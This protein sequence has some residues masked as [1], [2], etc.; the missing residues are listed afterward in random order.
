MDDALKPGTVIDGR[1]TLV[2]PLG[3]GNSGAVWLAEDN[4]S[5]SQ[6]VALKLLHPRFRESDH[7][8]ERLQR[9]A[10]LLARL[11]HPNIARPIAVRVDFEHP[12]LA[13]ELVQGLPLDQWMAARAN[14]PLG[15]E[16]IARIFAELAAAVAYAHSEGVIHRDLKPQNVMILERAGQRY[17]KVLDFGIAKLLEPS[18]D[19]TTHGRTVGSLFY[20]SPEQTRGEPA[21]RASDTFALGVILFELLTLRRA[22]AWDRQGQHLPAF[23]VAAGADGQNTV[24]TVYDRINSAPRPRPSSLRPGLPAAWDRLVM[25][26][27]AIAPGDRPESVEALLEGMR[28]A[29]PTP[30]GEEEPEA[31]RATMISPRELSGED[32]EASTLRG[33]QRSSEEPPPIVPT[34]QV[35]GGVS[36]FLSGTEV[37]VPGTTAVLVERLPPRGRT[38]GLGLGIAAASAAI[39]LGLWSMRRTPEEPA[40]TPPPP[41][42][43]MVAIA[44]PIAAPAA[45][46]TVAAAPEVEAAAKVPEEPRPRPRRAEARPSEPGRPRGKLAQLV[47]RLKAAPGD[48]ERLFALAEAIRGAA[49]RVQDPERRT[50]ILRLTSTSEMVGNAAGLEE[51]ARALTQALSEHGEVVP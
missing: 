27:L 41:P 34:Q 11:D 43:S 50:A 48:S 44:N 37:A 45:T 33:A 15:L 13:M 38:L 46:A 16:E 28:R 35:P 23:L 36:S 25:S 39:A 9:E 31:T 14:Q 42:P 4:V 18:T 1:F 32:E 20:M 7:A 47:N 19:G 29:L 30:R 24:A 49:P 51:A 8:K 17:V 10:Q 26:A 22:W 6:K 2:R 12:F 21:D 5:I 40:P 3:R